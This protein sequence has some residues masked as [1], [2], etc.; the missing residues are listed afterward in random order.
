[1]NFICDACKKMY[2]EKE[3]ELYNL[4]YCSIECAMVKRKK[5]IEYEE[6]KKPKYNNTTYGDILG[7]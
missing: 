1:M 6:A 7:F 4:N 2:C 5:M 3:F